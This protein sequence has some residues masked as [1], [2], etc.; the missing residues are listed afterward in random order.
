MGRTGKEGERVEE[1]CGKP[2]VWAGK[3]I[4]NKRYDAAERLLRKAIE[5]DP[6]FVPPYND[7][8]VLLMQQRKYPDAEKVLRRALEVDPKSPHALLNLGI[9]LNHL[10][11]YS[12][13]IPPLRETL[14][15]G[16][17]L[18]EI[19]QFK[20]AE[21]E[22]TRASKSSDADESVVQLCLGKLYARTGHFEKSIAAF[23]AYL[24]RALNAPNASEVRALIERMKCELSTRH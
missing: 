3:E 20:E 19:D 13:A 18:V 15:L 24:Q 22:L 23:N 21:Q 17:A 9:T 16:I 5:S 7:L 2:G 8:G 11:K 6:K 14:R 1:D 10:Q 12:D 4:K